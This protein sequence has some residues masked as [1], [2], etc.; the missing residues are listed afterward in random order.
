MLVE[1]VHNAAGYKAEKCGNKVYGKVCVTQD[2]D[3][4]A[5]NVIDVAED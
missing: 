2:S 5:S 1:S 3:G 4:H